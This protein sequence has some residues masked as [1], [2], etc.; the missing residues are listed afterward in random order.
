MGL[1]LVLRRRAGPAPPAFGAVAPGAP[2]FPGQ[3]AR[4][5]AVLVV[6]AAVLLVAAIGVGEPV[7][8]PADPADEQFFPYPE[9]YF[10]PH[11][12]LLRVLPGRW[13]WVGTL[14]VPLVF[15]GLLALP[16]LDRGGARP[17]RRR[18]VLGA[19]A[20]VGV[21]A[22][23]A[24]GLAWEAHVAAHRT[25]RT[26]IAARIADGEVDSIAAGRI[27]FDESGCL[28]CHVLHGQGQSLGPPL[29]GISRRVRDDFLVPFLRDP[30]AYFAEPT[31]PPWAGTREELRR[32]VAFL[33]AQ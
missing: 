23:I 9:W 24:L 7:R 16:L 18:I 32:L 33:R 21:A 11:Y 12:E 28:N 13:Q 17:A 31:M 6:G 19:V 26:P 25:D 14:Y 27:V 20:I 8:S 30:S 2:F 3:A 5:V 1:Q 22:T 4:I 15:A 29:T 10:L